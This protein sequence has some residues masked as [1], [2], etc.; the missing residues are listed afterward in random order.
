VFPTYSIYLEQF[1]IFIDSI[2]PD[3]T[4][5]YC[6]EDSDLSQLVKDATVKTIGYGIPEYSIENGITWIE[7]ENHKYQL[8]TFGQHNLMNL[9]S[10]MLACKEVGI[11]EDTFLK[12]ISTFK[13]AA[14]RLEKIRATDE[15]LFLEILPIRLLNL[16]QPV[17]AVVEQYKGFNTIGVFQLHT[18]SS[19]NADFLE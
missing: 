19:L 5:I 17:Q 14:K 7:T 13:G 1:K 16:K 6:K 3:G 18:F 12:S 2:E 4:L 8:E 11:N 15:I 10:A 9:N